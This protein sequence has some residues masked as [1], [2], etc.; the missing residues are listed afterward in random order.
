VLQ[1]VLPLPD[2][3]DGGGH[4]PLGGVI[5]GLC[6]GEPAGAVGDDTLFSIL[7]LL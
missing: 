5:H 1:V 6:N 3:D 7:K 2:V 4:L